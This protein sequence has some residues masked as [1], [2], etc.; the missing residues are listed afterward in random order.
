MAEFTVDD[1]AL[2][3]KF[4]LV[5]ASVAQHRTVRIPLALVESVSVDKHPWDSLS[6]IDDPRAPF[7]PNKEVFRGLQR[8]GSGIIRLIGPAGA[9]MFAHLST[10]G[11]AL[12][13]N[14]YDAAPYIGFLVTHR[15]PEAA[16]ADLQ[17]AM[18][19]Q[20]RRLLE[21]QIRELG[22]DHRE[23]LT[24]RSYVAI[25]LGQSGR[26][27]EA[28]GQFRQLLDDQIRELGRDDQDTLR[29]RGNLARWLVE[30]ERDQEAAGQ[31]RQLLDDQIRVLGPDHPDVLK[32]R[33]NLAL[34]LARAGRTEDSV[35]QLRRLV[36]DQVRVLGPGHPTTLTTINI[37]AQMEEVVK[38]RRTT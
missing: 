5:E 15:D 9:E 33:N 3:V 29:T 7:A 6:Q 11:P 13:V 22:R 38:K 34:S 1:S 10:M 14:L 18:L 24:T 37:L 31:F 8:H 36:D 2:V 30:L 17:G 32:S 20:F 26:A 12:R 16:A 28:A 4:S 19:G 25:W 27:E 35:S 21:D 23:T